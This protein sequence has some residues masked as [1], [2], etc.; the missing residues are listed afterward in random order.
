MLV[1]VNRLFVKEELREEFEL[2]IAS[3]I[4]FIASSTV[5]EYSFERPVEIPMG[6]ADHYVLRSVWRD[7]DHLKGWMK[8]PGFREAHTLLENQ[9][10][11]YFQEN[12][13]LAYEVVG[14]SSRGVLTGS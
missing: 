9:Q 11:F 8:S 7:L 6:K 4:G 10:E 13:L 1:V 5:L 14:H 2:F 12:E 3:R